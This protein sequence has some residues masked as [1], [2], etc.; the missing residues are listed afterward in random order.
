MSCCRC[1][2]DSDDSSDD[3]RVT[4]N[5]FLDSFVSNCCGKSVVVAGEHLTHWYSCT[6]CGK[7]TNLVKKPV[8]SKQ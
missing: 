6:G 4:T 2:R 8:E 1:R 3:N 5:S 7:G